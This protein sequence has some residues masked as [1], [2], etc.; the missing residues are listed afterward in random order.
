M[1]LCGIGF[2]SSELCARLRRLPWGPPTCEIAD[3]LP[4]FPATNC[5]GDLSAASPEVWVCPAGHI[6]VADVTSS[7]RVR[8]GYYCGEQHRRGLRTTAQRHRHDRE[9]GGRQTRDAVHPAE[10]VDHGTRV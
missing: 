6:V 7:H 3:H 2:Q 1:G 4:F 8:I 10:V 5:T 9:V